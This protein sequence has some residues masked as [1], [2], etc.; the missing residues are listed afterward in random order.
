MMLCGA[1]GAYQQFFLDIDKTYPKLVNLLKSKPWIHGIDLDIEEEVDINNIKLLIN[2]INKDFGDKFI[3]TMAPVCG[4]LMSD[5]PG[6]GNFSYK[7]LY[8]SPEGK[9]IHWFNTQSYNGSFNKS[10]ID[11]I[12]KNNYPVNKIVMGMMS[13]D[14]NSNSFPNALQEV[15]EILIEYPDFG[16]VFDWEYLDAPPDKGNPHNWAKSFKSIQI[17]NDG[18]CIIF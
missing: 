16:G 3:I 13:G 6:M 2:K 14:Y 9:K 11:Q 18:A 5:E 17:N 12:V 1:G 10:T 4:S 15:K 7:E 8:N